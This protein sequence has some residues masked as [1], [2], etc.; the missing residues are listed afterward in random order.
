MR[1][2]DRVAT[3]ARMPDRCFEWFEYKGRAPPREGA[4]HSHLYPGPI[5]SDRLVFACS[6]ERTMSLDTAVMGQACGGELRTADQL[7]GR[8]LDRFR[9][10]LATGR[11]VTVSCTLQ[12][13]LFDEV[14]EEAG[15]EDRV[16]YAKI[17]ETA[18]WSSDAAAAG[19]K[20]AALLAA[21][22]E[23]LPDAATVALESRGVA[24]IYGRDEVAVEAGRRLAEHLDITVLLT[25]P[26][27][28]P[29]LH[30]NAFP[31]LQG[32][33]RTAKGYLGAFELGIDDY[34]LPAPSSRTHLVFGAPRNGAVSTCDL[35]IDLSAGAPLFPAHAVRSGYLR[36]DPGD[37]AA[38]ERVLAEASH[39]VGTFDKPRFID[40]HGDL[41]AHSRSRITGCTRCLDVCPTGAIAPAGDTV[42][43]DPYVCAGCGSCAAICP[44]GAA[45]YALPTSD[46]LMRRLRSLMRAYRKAGGQ[47]ALVLVHDG[48]HGEPLIDA[49]GRYGDGLPAHVLPVQ[50]NEVTQIGPEVIAALFAYGAAGIRL[51]AR[52]RAKHDLEPLYRTLTLGETLAQALGYGAEDGGRLVETIETDDPDLLGA[53]LRQATPGR[54]AAVPAG[55]LFLGNKREV[56]RHTFRGMHSAAPAP[57]D[58]VPLAAGAP[59]G[60]L[61]FRVADCTLCLACVSACPTHALS[62]S[63]EQPL[64]G[65]EESLCVQCGLC[66]ATCPED[67]IALRPQVDFAAWAAP[68]RVVKEEEPFCCTQCAKPFGTR[69]TIERIVER[70]RER[71]WMF[72]GAGGEARLQAL[73]MCEDC[74]VE[75]AVNQG[76]DPHAAPE[77]DKPRTTEDYLRARA[78]S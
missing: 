26:G 38:V 67:V 2:R 15:A 77:R 42:H 11:P 64:L 71:H 59:F 18:G 27:E 39:L 43:I 24:L 45:A 53:A 63:A 13:P 70:L 58:R 62:D 23:P 66:A 35:V 37:P 75:V 36:A 12:A 50:V 41:C 47:N 69:S 51:L 19:P 3:C 46:A 31:V 76:F 61:D 17:R 10:A 6:C 54:Q 33:I 73:S 25:R 4:S 56:L 74:R 34:A 14:A 29:P 49:L 9:E 1:V 8:E 57:V 52:A 60:G 40:F 21:A 44:T 16:A 30:R 78:G 68:R 72:S 7:C 22:A 48:D 65:F 28:I 55:L 5:L 32:T 20:M